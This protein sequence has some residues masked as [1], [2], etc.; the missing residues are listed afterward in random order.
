MKKLTMILTAAL[1]ALM[2]GLTAT[3][4]TTPASE[5][6]DAAVKLLFYT[7]NVTLNAKAEFSLDGEWFK[8]ADISL[9][10][11]HNRSVRQLQLTSPKADGTE[12]KNGYTIVTEEDKLYLMEVF[13]PGTYR[14]GISAER[15]SIL[16]KS[17]ESGQLLELGYALAGQANLLLGGDA[18]KEAEDGTVTIA[19]GTDAPLLVNAALDQVFSF[20]AERY[21][22]L[23]YDRINA[24]GFISMESFATKSEGLAYATRSV[25]ARDIKITVKKDAEGNLQHAEGTISLEVQTCADGLHQLDITLSADVTDRGSTMLKKFNPDDYGVTLAEDTGIE[26]YGEEYIPEQPE[27]FVD[28]LCLN[29]MQIWSETGV[30]MRKTDSVGCAWT[31]GEYEVSIDGGGISAKTWFAEDGSLIGLEIQPNDWLNAPDEL[32]DFEPETDTEQDLAARQ[33][34]LDFIGKI[35]PEMLDVVKDMKMA[36][37]IDVDGAV[38]AQYNEE[39]IVQE[40]NGAMVVIQ[41]EPAMQIEYFNCVSNG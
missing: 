19:F 23:D 39:P 33:F 29:A 37:K 38:Y 26:I 36:W 4:E 5:L 9:K 34:I 16:R 13:T 40:G 31:D 27:G 15:D 3:A 22:G 35:K 30:D 6:Y 7:N 28:D 10:Q 2:I 1:L 12:R 25:S 21:F 24:T 18:V 14:I 32:Y 41:L 8:T 11:D 17:V 20:A